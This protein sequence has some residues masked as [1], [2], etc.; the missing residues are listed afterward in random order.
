MHGCGSGVCHPSPLEFFSQE[1]LLMIRSRCQWLGHGPE[2]ELG[3]IC[4]NWSSR[5]GLA[6]CNLWPEAGG[7]MRLRQAMGVE[8]R[9]IT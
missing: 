6:N 4:G 3:F 9:G 7:I 1:S 5:L 8:C 2:T